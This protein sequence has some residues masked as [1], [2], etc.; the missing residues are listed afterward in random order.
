MKCADDDVY[1]ELQRRLIEEQEV[2]HYLHSEDRQVAFS[3]NPKQNSLS[4][5]L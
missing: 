4:F 1:R 5:W 3:D 2:F